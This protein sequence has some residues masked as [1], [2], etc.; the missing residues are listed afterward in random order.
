MANDR[1]GLK[2]HLGDIVHLTKGMRVGRRKKAMVINI[3]GE[4]ITVNTYS[5]CIDA[6]RYGNEMVIVESVWHGYQTLKRNRKNEQG[7]SL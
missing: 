2:L 7:K 3:D 1:C 4:D 5:G 6:H